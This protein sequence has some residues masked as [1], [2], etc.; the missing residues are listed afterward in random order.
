MSIIIINICSGDVDNGIF[1]FVRIG[2]TLGS[3]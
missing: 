3:L 1:S 2:N